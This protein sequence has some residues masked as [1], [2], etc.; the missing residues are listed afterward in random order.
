M[1][2]IIVP[3]GADSAIIRR[4]EGLSDHL[5][6]FIPAATNASHPDRAKFERNGPY[7]AMKLSTRYDHTLRF[8]IDA[9]RF[10]RVKIDANSL[11]FHQTSEQRRRH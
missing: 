11:N 3:L 10:R 2:L 5:G 8:G 1:F 6:M 7:N 4:T 9:E